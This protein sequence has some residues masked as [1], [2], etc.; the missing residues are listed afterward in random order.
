MDQKTRPFLVIL[1][2]F[3]LASCPAAAE[4]FDPTLSAKADAFQIFAEE[5]HGTGLGALTGGVAFTD[6]TRQEIACIHHQGDSTI[7]T[8][9][10]LGAEALRYMVTRDAGARAEVMRVAKYLHDAMDITDTPGYVARYAGPDESP[11]NCNYDDSAGWKVHG[12]GE[13]DGFFWVHETSRDQYSGY[14]MGMT[15]AFDAL[16]DDTAPD[17]VAMRA[18]IKQD[19][20]DVIEMLVQNRWHITDENGEW[21]GN[22]ASWIGPSKRLAWLVQA[23]HV[24]DEE[25]YWELLDQQYEQN[26]AL[27]GIDTWAFINKYME[28]YGNNLRHLDYFAVFRYWPD[29]ARLDEYWRIWNLWNRPYVENTHNPWFDGVHV[30]GCLRLGNCDPVE[31]DAISADFVNTLGRYFEPPAW[32]RA[33]TCLP[34]DLDD[35]SV[36]A[37]EFLAGVPWLEDIIDINPQTAMARE[38]DDRHWTDMYWQSTPFEAGCDHGADPTFA[39]PG[40]DFLLAY[41]LGVYYGLLPGD[42][43]YGDDDLIET[44][45]DTVDDDTDDDP[46]EHWHEN[47]DD[48]ASDDD[49]ADDDDNQDSSSESSSGDDG[50]CGC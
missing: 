29:R 47:Y 42:G 44:D 30:A 39:G 19:L 4:E 5:W 34:H 31:I 24:I 27:L 2:A 15:L 18:T 12:V 43:P 28:Y 1:A 38:I 36:W 20:A 45:D 13:W 33:V 21:T 25:Y 10:Y 46:W 41:W 14:F 8:G 9:M 37:D 11:W 22:N 7:W 35:F 26:K 48:D 50:A 17:A 49:T 40:M 23:A 16:A 3:L 32:K 6:E